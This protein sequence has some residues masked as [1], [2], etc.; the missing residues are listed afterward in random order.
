LTRGNGDDD[1]T[2]GQPP[3][4]CD[5]VLT[6]DRGQNAVPVGSDTGR[7]DPDHYEQSPSCD[8]FTLAEVMGCPKAHAVD[9][10]TDMDT[11]AAATRED[12]PPEYRKK[13]VLEV[14]T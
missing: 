14:S 8:A 6:A 1:T 2:Q 10:G 9:A 12:R 4:A 13:H 7:I 3:F 11:L 5:V